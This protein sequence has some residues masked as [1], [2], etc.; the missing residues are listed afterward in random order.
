MTL[1]TATSRRKREFI[2]VNPSQVYDDSFFL[3]EG[4]SSREVLLAAIE[5]ARASAQSNQNS[6]GL[7]PEDVVPVS[8]QQLQDKLSLTTTALVSRIHRAVLLERE[9]VLDRLVWQI[10][11]G[12]SD[13]VD[14][15]N[16]SVSNEMAY[17]I[18]KEQPQRSLVPHS[19]IGDPLQ[20]CVPEGFTGTKKKLNITMGKNKS[21]VTVLA[22]GAYGLVDI[23]DIQVLYALIILTIDYHT[24]YKE[25]MTKDGKRKVN[26]T[27]IH[28][29]VLLKMLGKA[30]DRRP[31]RHALWRHITKLRTTEYDIHSMTPHMTDGEKELFSNNQFRFISSSASLSEQASEKEEDVAP[32]AY[33]IEWHPSMFE[34]M[35]LKK[36]LF[37]FPSSV[38]S[39]PSNMFKLYLYLRNGMRNSD[40]KLTISLDMLG[41]IVFDK[42]ANY[43]DLRRFTYS[44]LK[45]CT[46]NELEKFNK[47]A[48]KATKKNQIIFFRDFYGFKIG[49]SLSGKKVFTGLVVIKDVDKFLEHCNTPRS[50]AGSSAAPTV[51]NPLYNYTTV[52]DVNAVPSLTEK[53]DSAEEPIVVEEVNLKSLNNSARVEFSMLEITMERTLNSAHIVS[54]DETI[55]YYITKDTTNREIA[56]FLDAIQPSVGMELTNSENYL[57]AF[58]NTLVPLSYYGKELDKQ[59]IFELSQRTSTPERKIGFSEIMHLIA[60]NPSLKKAIIKK[61]IT[62]QTI[63]GVLFIL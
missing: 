26:R 12:Q 38:F 27:P 59:L 25:W 13:L 42:K 31:A 56:L 8:L 45:T 30:N 54:K 6:E 4:K 53:G 3:A 49:L 39:E 55:S 60:S 62:Q 37:S 51:S 9:T 11:A 52:K 50:K 24:T 35:F 36:Y 48:S 17:P 2:L 47:A 22:S 57:R 32:V 19:P 14:T 44:F 29:S 10:T 33:L 61:G 7:F 15:H 58:R 20:F 16:K 28:S 23:E 43:Y 46:P 34:A 40:G 1:K 41:H 21:N 18:I 5:I 63:D